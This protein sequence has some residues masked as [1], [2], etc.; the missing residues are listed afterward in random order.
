MQLKK[1]STIYK[2]NG[3]NACLIFSYPFLITVTAQSSADEILDNSSK[4]CNL[5]NKVE[6]EVTEE[7]LFAYDQKKT[8]EM[9][10][11]AV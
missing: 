1:E 9:G 6:E 7:M 11:L 8:L 10:L 3:P 4:K 2:E 5:L